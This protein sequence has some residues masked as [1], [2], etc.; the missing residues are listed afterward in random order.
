MICLSF[1]IRVIRRHCVLWKLLASSVIFAI[2]FGIYVTVYRRADRTVIIDVRGNDI[3]VTDRAASV[4]SSPNYV[5]ERTTCVHETLV[6]W[7]PYFK[8]YF[9]KPDSLKCSQTEENWVYASKGKLYVSPSA[10]MRHVNISCAYK[11]LHHGV[12]DF[13]TRWGATVADVKSGSP[14]V[15]DFFKVKCT[16]NDSAT[17]DNI[18]AGIAPIAE[19]STTGRNGS[20][21][22]NV[23]M[24]GF[25]SVSRMTW[26][27]NLPKSY[28]YLVTVLGAVVMEGYNIVGDGTPQALLPILTGKTEP[29]LPEARR[30]HRNAKPVDEHPWIWKDFKKLGYVTQFAEDRCHIGTFTYRMLGF[31]ETPVDHYMRTYYLEA[32]KLNSRSQRLCT[33]SLSR[34]NIFLNYGLEM[35]RS[36]PT[37]TRKFSFLFNVELSHDALNQMQLAD[38]DVFGLLKELNDDGHLD[39]T[40]LIMMSDHGARFSAVRSFVQGN[41]VCS[42]HNDLR[43]FMSAVRQYT[44]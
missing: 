7:P 24:I 12:D 22:L 25:D 8:K 26:M 34:H 40:L 42:T 33:G 11:P 44:S 29:E 20:L 14:L 28:N 1:V 39:N 6:L 38:D 2:Y 3:S 31:R 9:R 43:C 17:Y 19:Q 23:L 37:I 16:A 35:F 15:T 13:H 21:D 5:K 30:G 18:H 27:R 36:Y 41:Y 10:A 32:E 4:T